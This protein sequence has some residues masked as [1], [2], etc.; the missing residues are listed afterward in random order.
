MGSHSTNLTTPALVIVKEEP[1]RHVWMNF[2]VKNPAA[3]IHGSNAESN[4]PYEDYNIMSNYI[5]EN[6]FYVKETA[7]ENI[8]KVFS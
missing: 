1:K 6:R 8:L 4:L 7:N 2:V 3:L 5:I